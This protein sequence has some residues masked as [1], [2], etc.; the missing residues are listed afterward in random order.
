[1]PLTFCHFPLKALRNVNEL[2]I[3]I[4]KVYRSL[5]E[6]PTFHYLTKLKLHSI[7]YNW[8]LLVQVLNHCPNLQHL[9]LSQGTEPNLKTKYIVKHR[10]IRAAW[11][12]L[13]ETSVPWWFHV[14][15]DYPDYL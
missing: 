6:I 2:Y 14:R 10:R 3:E 13:T 8:N 1:M 9:Q 12:A 15:S 4:N 5:D 11:M 7:N